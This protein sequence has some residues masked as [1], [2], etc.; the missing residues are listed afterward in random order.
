MKLTQLHGEYLRLEDL[1]ESGGLTES[2]ITLLEEIKFV[3]D[4]SDSS[5]PVAGDGMKSA[6]QVFSK[7]NGFS[8]IGDNVSITLTKRNIYEAMETYASQFK[9]QPTE[10][11]SAEQFLA[12]K[13]GYDNCA[14]DLKEKIV[15]AMEAYKNQPTKVSFLK[16]KFKITRR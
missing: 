12:D 3:L 8:A 6:E 13:L 16:S 14:T 15:S 2:G 7:V 1:R 11:K 10:M 9:T 5:V 4:T